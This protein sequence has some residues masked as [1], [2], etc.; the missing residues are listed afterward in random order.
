[1]R[2]GENM[3]KRIAHIL[4]GWSPN[5]GNAFFQLGGLHVLK[6]VMPDARYIYIH[7]QPGY[8]SYWNPKGGNPRNAFDM[9]EIIDVDYLVLMGP[10]FRPEIMDIWGKSLENL[11]KRNVKLILLGVAAMDYS[12]SMVSQYEEFL[13]RFPPYLMT[14]RDSDTFNLLGKYADNALD[15][16]DFAFFMPDIYPLFGFNLQDPY[17]ALSFDKIPEPRISIITNGSN[18]SKRATEFEF[19]GDT[20]C[21]EPNGFRTKLARRSRVSMMLEGMLFPGNQIKSV[22]P[23]PIIRSD[24]RYSPIFPRKTFR[25]PSVIVNDV[26]FPYF[27][28]YGNA[29][30]TMTD[31][32]HAAVI[33]LVYGKHAMLFSN[34]PRLRLLERVGIEGIDKR[35]ACL[36]LEKINIEKQKI[37]EFLKANL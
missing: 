27:E 25:Y 34:S 28:L 1:V 36:D 24:H 10:M 26:P 30:L 2:K 7:E 31:R 32:L 14:T 35:P 16:I 18:S 17:I 12:P 9:T 6:K 22:G 20:W 15:G 37:M 8:P 5:I 19:N 11:K 21:V 29:E 4:G 33:S 23:Y 3:E 13:R